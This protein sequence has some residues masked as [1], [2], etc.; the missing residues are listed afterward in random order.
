MIIHGDGSSLWTMT[1]NS[2]FAKAFVRLMGNIHAIGEAVHITSD[3]SLTWNQI[4]AAIANSLNVELKAVHVTSDFLDKCS[5]GRYDFCGG[6]TGDKANSVVFNNTKL[7]RLVP[8]FCASV[9]FDEG[10][11]ICLYNILNNPELQQEDPEFDEWC[12][13]VIAALELA[14]KEF[15]TL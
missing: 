2:D 10:I 4:Y 3:E 11:K 13:K 5:Q 1:H 15:Q 7:K 6:L 12:D 8:E 14:Y 9:R